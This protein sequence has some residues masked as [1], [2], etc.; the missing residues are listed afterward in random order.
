MIFPQHSHTISLIYTSR[1]VVEHMV[2]LL[3]GK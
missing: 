3:G 1:S 2:D